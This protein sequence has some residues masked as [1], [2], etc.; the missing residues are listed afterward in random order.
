[1]PTDIT[2]CLIFGFNGRFRLHYPRFKKDRDSGGY[3]QQ[4]LIASLA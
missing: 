2:F 1:M 3:N 4:D